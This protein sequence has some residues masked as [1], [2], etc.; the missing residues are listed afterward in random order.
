[1]R[2]RLLGG[3]LALAAFAP[4]AAA[5]TQPG[6]TA[7][8]GYPNGGGYGGG[9]NGYGVPAAGFG[10]N[11]YNR[12]YQPLSPYLNL[13][14]GGDPG[15][16]YFYGVRPGLPGN[17]F[18]NPGQGY[19]GGMGGG[20]YGGGRSGGLSNGFLPAAGNPYSEPLEFP[21]TGKP[22]PSFRSSGHPVSFGG[23]WPSSM[24]INRVTSFGGQN[25]GVVGP[26]NQA[27]TGR[28][29]FLRNPATPAA[30]PAT[31]KK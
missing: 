31:P 13:L 12:Q 6:F 2:T 4:G 15:I 23:G 26:A 11:A 5:Q 21:E 14:R 25:G 8:G 28:S 27:G 17:G 24:G 7:G 3:L 1:M 29:A 19:G 9:Y 20:A 18:A 22:V 10:P 16:N 30:Q